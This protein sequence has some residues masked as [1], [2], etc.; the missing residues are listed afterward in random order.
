MQTYVSG[1][2]RHD[3]VKARFEAALEQAR[4]L[5]TFTARYRMTENDHRFRENR[6]VL[7]GP[8]LLQRATHP[9]RPIFQVRGAMIS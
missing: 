6:H 5:Y 8:R 2:W 3:I 4:R 1:A 9:R 7:F